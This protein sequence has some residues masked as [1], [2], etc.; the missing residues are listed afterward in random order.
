[1][2]KLVIGTWNIKNSYF[3][4]HK[5]SVKA[6]AIKELLI[7]NG[8]DI[9][10]LQEVNGILSN[11][12]EKEL[13]EIGYHFDHKI[14]DSLTILGDI[15][16]EGNLVV[17]R[18]NFVTISE[19]N[20]LTSIPEKVGFKDLISYRKRYINKVLVKNPEN[21]INVF[22]THL[23]PLDYSLNRRQLTELGIMLDGNSKIPTIVTGNLNSKPDDIN[24]LEFIGTLS[25][26]GFT[27]IRTNCKTYIKHKDNKQVDYIIVPKSFDVEDVKV[28]V[29]FAKVSSHYPVIAKV[30]SK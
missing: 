17:V 2:K 9:L 1:M 29:T 5:N 26:K 10:S 3:N 15:R 18:D 11:H 6:E 24:M 19:I 30:K 21:R 28:D 4:L 25:K 27:F 13:S 7:E 20:R 23:E 8:V 22:N 16:K 12:L 14:A